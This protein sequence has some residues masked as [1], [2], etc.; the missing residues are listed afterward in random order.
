M[1][2]VRAEI[3]KLRRRRGLMAWAALLT[4]G[5]VLVAYAVL[6]ALHAANAVRHGP[7]GGAENLKNLSWLLTMIGGVAAVMVGTTAGSQ[8]RAGGVFRDLVVTGRSRRTLFN[9]RVPGAL[10]VYLPLLATGFALAVA[11]S[12]AFAGGL[13]TP[14][15]HDVAHHGLA[16]GSFGV[17][18]LVVAVA[19]GSILPARIATAVVIGWNAVLANTLASF[20]VLGDAR[21]AIDLSAAMHFAPSVLNEDVV[22]PMSTGTALLVL[23]LWVAVSL[24][25]GAWWTKRLD[26]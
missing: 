17:V 15:L 11:G 3:L 18:T 8:D 25:A 9:V 6:L 12:Y 21:K 19:L 1:R 13:A 5:S 26:A 10:A 7:A 24:R 4:V 22:V 2:L 16:V 20:T 23:A 14:S